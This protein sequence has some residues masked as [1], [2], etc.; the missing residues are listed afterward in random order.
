MSRSSSTRGVRPR[1][2]EPL[3]P[4]RGGAKVSAAAPRMEEVR[5]PPALH[6]GSVR[7]DPLATILARSVARRSAPSQA[8]IQRTTKSAE[9]LTKLGEPQIRRGPPVKVQ[10]QFVERPKAQRPTLQRSKKSRERMKSLAIPHVGQGPTDASGPIVKDIVDRLEQVLVTDR[11]ALRTERERRFHDLDWGMGDEGGAL[12]LGAIELTETPDAGLPQLIDQAKF[13][14]RD[15]RGIGTQAF[16]LVQRAGVAKQL[17][18]NTLLTMDAADQL[19]YLRESGLVG[20]DWK[21]VAEVHYYRKRDKNMTAFH[22]DTRG[23]TLF[24]NL[25]FANT[26][27]IPGP[28]YI[29]NPGTVADYDAYVASKLPDTFV[30]DLTE[31]KKAYG[32]ANEREDYALV[33]MTRIDPWGFVSFV[34]EAVH[35]KTPTVRHRMIPGPKLKAAITSKAHPLVLSEIEAAYDNQKVYEGMHPQRQGARPP[36][37]ASFSSS[38]RFSRRISHLVGKDVAKAYGWYNFMEMHRAGKFDTEEFDRGKIERLLPELLSKAELEALIEQ[39]DWER[40]PYPDFNR[41]KFKHVTGYGEGNPLEIPVKGE[42]KYLKRQMSEAALTGEMPR[43]LPEGTPRRFLRTWIRAV[44]P[45]QD[46]G[47]PEVKTY[48]AEGELL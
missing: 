14:K 28:E 13:I 3:P 7:D 17:V 6:Q 22:K 24:V 8:M 45:S 44:H 4:E 11:A 16:D 21:I 1:S 27:V 47:P 39:A 35:H 32:K 2:A 23:E 34:D 48:G 40:V 38:E 12:M 43:Q 36:L 20:K 46:Q 30:K 29:V 33:G 26:D 37:P 42:K 18:A 15:P 25:N 5:T 41:V 10:K 31:A 19:A 9:Q